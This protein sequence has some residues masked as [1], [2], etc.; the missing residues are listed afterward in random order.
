MVKEYLIR[1]IWN[2]VDMLEN[3][4]HWC[5]A[6]WIKLC[7]KWCDKLWLGKQLIVMLYMLSLGT[8]TRIPDQKIH[9]P[10][11]QV[12]KHVIDSVKA[13][14]HSHLDDQ[15]T[16]FSVLPKMDKGRWTPRR[17]PFK[18]VRIPHSRGTQPI[19]TLV[20]AGLFSRRWGF[21]THGKLNPLGL[22]YRLVSSPAIWLKHLVPD[23][24]F[25]YPLLHVTVLPKEG[26]SNV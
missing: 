16:H 13:Y 21:H 10:V 1:H 22:W 3:G 25:L 17:R 7:I 23:V 8:Q 5:I 20:P 4:N 24:Y 12:P 6:Q 19:R 2:K 9:K 14:F 26:Q 18:K 11:Q 15:S